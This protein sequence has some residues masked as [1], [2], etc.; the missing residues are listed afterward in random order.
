MLLPVRPQTSADETA[1]TVWQWH[2]IGWS[3]R[4]AGWEGI[5]GVYGG[6]GGMYGK[7]LPTDPDSTYGMACFWCGVADP[8]AGM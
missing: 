3:G 7:L 4:S 8:M 5:S 6:F 2:V 1:G